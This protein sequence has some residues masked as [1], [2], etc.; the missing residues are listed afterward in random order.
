MQRDRRFEAEME[1]RKKWEGWWMEEIQS[2]D[3]NSTPT[4]PRTAMPT[5][6]ATTTAATTTTPATREES[7]S[8]YVPTEEGHDD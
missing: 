1:R 8:E 6:P 4:A 2:W 7:G 5:T 3:D